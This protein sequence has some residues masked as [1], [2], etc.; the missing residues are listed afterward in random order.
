M[1]DVD[2]DDLQFCNG[3]ETCNLSTNLCEA[4]TPVDC[5]DTVACTVDSCNE[6]TDA[7]DNTPDDGACNDGNI[8]TDNS[9]DLVADCQYVNNTSP[10]EDG[11]LCTGPDFCTG[12]ACITGAT[13]DC[14]DLITCTD[15]SCNS[16]T[17]CQNDDNCPA[18][19]TC[20]TGLDICEAVATAPPLPIVQG[21]TW[22]YFKGTVEP[23]TPIGA[24]SWAQVGFDDSLWLS[25]PS[26]FGYGDISAPNTLL[27]DMDSDGPSPLNGTGYNS[28]YF[29]REFSITNPAAVDSLILTVDY[30][31]A[32]V[33]Y[34]NGVEVVRTAGLLADGDGTPQGV[35]PLF[36]Q[37]A[38]F[39]TSTS[40]GGDQNHESSGGSSAP[41]N[42]PQNYDIGLG[43]TTPTPPAGVTS[44]TFVVY[45]G[46]L[47]SLLQ[48]GNNVIAIHGHNVTS[49]S[50]DF[51]IVPTLD[52][53]FDAGCTVDEDCDDGEDCTDDTCNTGTG[54]CVFTP[55]DLNACTDGESCTDDACVAGACISTPN[56]GNSCTDSVAC[57]NDACSTGTC[58]ST[59]NCT[60]GQV[61]N[62][63]TGICETPVSLQAGDVIISG[64]QPS[65]TDEWVELFNTTTSA[66]SLDSL[67]LIVRIDT[68]GDGSATIDWQLPAGLLTG[69]TIAPQ[70]FFLLR[71]G[72]GPPAGDLTG[73]LDF[74]TGEGGTRAISLEL[75]IEGAHMDYLV[76]GLN[77]AEP[78]GTADV[79]PGDLSFDG[80]TFPRT[81]VI[82]SCAPLSAGQCSAS[83]PNYSEGAVL[84][85]TDTALYAGYD[86]EGYF[87]DET[88]L[89][90]GFPNGVW[91]SDHTTTTV[92]DP[93]N[94]GSPTVPPPTGTPCTLD[95]ECTDNDV[96]NGVETCN[97]GTGFCQNGTAL[98]CND[99]NVCTDDSCD[100][101]AGCETTNNTD[102]CNDL[103]ACTSGDVCGAGVCLGVPISCDDTVSCTDDSCDTLLGCQNVDNCPGGQACNLGTGICES[104]PVILT[105]Q[106]DGTYTG[107]HDTFL[108]ESD[109]D[110]VKGALED[111][112]YDAEDPAPNQNIGVLRFDGIVGLSAGQ[113]P[114]GTTITSAT[115]TL[116]VFNPSVVP[117]GEIRL[118][119]VGW[120]QATAT[121]NN[122]G[123]EAGVQPD[124]VG[125]L[126]ALGPITNGSHDI[127]VTT[128][129]QGWVDNP[130][131]NFG[132][133]FVPQAI[134]GL[135]MRSSEYVADPS[136]RPKLTVEYVDAGAVAQMTCSLSSTTVA[137]NGSVDLEVFLESPGG[138]VDVRGYQTQIQIA[139]TSGSGSASVPCPGGVFIDEARSDYLF[140]GETDVS[141]AA[142]CSLLR[143]SASKL[144][145][146]TTVGASSVYLSEYTV[147]VAAGTTAGT[148]FDIS[149]VA[150]PGSRLA[151]ASSQEL[152]VTFGPVCTL[153]V[154]GCGLDSECDDGSLC[155][156]DTCNAGT[157]ENVPID[158]SGAGD[159]C[160][161]GVCNPG[162]GLCE[163]QPANEG[164]TCDDLDACTIGDVC[165]GGVCSGPPLNCTDASACTNDACVAGICVYTPSGVCSLE[166]DI[167][168]YRD[169]TAGGFEPSAKGVPSVD[170][171][172]DQDIVADTTSVSGG[173]Y[174]LPA[175]GSP[176][177]VETMDKFGVSTISDHNGA[178]SSFD[179][180]FIAQHAV[181]IGTPLSANQLVAG[182]VSG[183]GSVTSFDAAQVA[184]F[185]AGLL[186]GN[187]FQVAFNGGSDWA[188]FRCDN[189]VDASNQDCG[190]PSYL[191]DPL[192]A[193]EL[194][195]D[196][197]AVLYG[198]VTGNWLPATDGSRATRVDPTSEL[199]LRPTDREAE[200]RQQDQALGEQLRNAEWADRL[201]ILEQLPDGTLL[202]GVELE[203]VPTTMEVVDGVRRQT[204]LV[205]M[206]NGD[207]IQGLDLEISYASAEV[208]V[209]DV[210]TGEAAADFNLLSNG[211]PGAHRIALYGVL[212]L[213]GT[214]TMLEMTVEMPLGVGK[215]GPFEV[216]ALA[217]ERSIPVRV[218]KGHR[219]LE[220]VTPRRLKVE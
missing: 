9:C 127:D 39:P 213:Q 172:I 89:L 198:D 19:E 214:G 88:A 132:L 168:Y 3:V 38:N 121:W 45:G 128:A 165:T 7:C 15:D 180:S 160:N 116:E 75:V 12:G 118:A 179:A 209:V 27:P 134:D 23:T 159:Q 164:L 146:S 122:F 55:D 140:F 46:T 208:R 85:L 201:A 175:A 73:A 216:S 81:E 195:D 191:H 207:G 194:D 5:D 119:L 29:R 76:Y 173:A 44:G 129:V 33:A 42:P 94:S 192:T 112:E 190:P 35:P 6:G 124:E 217:N 36:N 162:T 59:D 24:L 109:P 17:G 211:V 136:V 143:A 210:R 98:V 188:F 4:G 67:E 142:T 141:W 84:R 8:C 86:V 117:E 189:Y 110:V 65:G 14:D 156:T 34:I 48:A 10:C 50:S 170:I 133:L 63:G 137:P 178:I 71:E 130:A 83:P 176:L 107:T 69:A 135:Q 58:L 25:G 31:D 82:R 186:P 123:G 87:T 139:L 138:D 111:W 161:D 155:T 32:F 149:F 147:E 41:I 126:V 151:D 20:N 185:A 51:V 177:L 125:A 203:L 153:T 144:S 74:A 96:C 99:G 16:G 90:S 218:Q 181:G 105:F 182:D 148:T 157:C 101:I 60:G 204:Y 2:C 37:L 114:Q 79:P 1:G 26:G 21:D 70:G 131:T 193:S 197:H 152:P 154:Q 108:M 47:A 202:S 215:V 43:T 167:F 103:N 13:V 56:D 66:V 219:A 187:H 145:G 184:Q 40:P 28:V 169:N 68:N 61:C 91:T 158:C 212:P 196:F 95:S 171:D 64:F 199:V 100:P 150:S 52:A 22:T 206:R 80:V 49:T 11:D 62:V 200:V 78:G 205:E 72:A 54:E 115:L 166:G 104:G 113:I 57:T 183:N 18:G 106:N 220:T 174:V 77:T 92:S 97:L 120:D 30:D 53:T 163:S 93:R 102:P